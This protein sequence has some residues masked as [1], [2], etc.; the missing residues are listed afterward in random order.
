[1]VFNCMYVFKKSICFE[2][3][4]QFLRQMD[5]LI[6]DLHLVY[7]NN[8]ITIAHPFYL[9]SM[10]VNREIHSNFCLIVL[11]KERASAHPVSL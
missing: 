2:N 8:V 6:K 5:F 9:L 1:M 7:F 3:S 11:V 4:K 10:S